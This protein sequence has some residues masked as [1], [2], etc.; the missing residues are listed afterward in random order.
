M[1]YKIERHYPDISMIDYNDYI[2]LGRRAQAR[3]VRAAF[4]SLSAYVRGL[5]Q[6]QA[7]RIADNS[8]RPLNANCQS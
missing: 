5:L 8:A 3:E 2:Q 7:P 6:F 1:S 4:A